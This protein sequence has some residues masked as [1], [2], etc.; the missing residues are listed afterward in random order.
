MNWGAAFQIVVTAIVSFGG[1]G[2]IISAVIKFTSNRI[3]DR[4]QKRYELKLSKELEN[5][6]SKLS[7]EQEY[8][9]SKLGQRSYVSQTRFDAEFKIYRELS[10]AVVTMVKEIERLFPIVTRDLDNNQKA[11]EER[12]GIAREKVVVF[13]CVLATNAPFISEE[14]Y[15]FFRALEEKCKEQLRDFIDFR[16]ASDA[17]RNVAECREENREAYK[18]TREIRSDLDKIIQNLREYLA[19]LEAL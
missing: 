13:E 5:F 10:G 1:A 4:L 19:T 9:K 18:R 3:A 11:L 12:Y 8:F 2:A 7:K 17:S 15:K 16:L 14:V 6:K